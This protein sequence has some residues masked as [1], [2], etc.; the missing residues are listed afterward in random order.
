[1]KG[2][3]LVDFLR[4]EVQ[5][6]PAL[7]NYNH[8]AADIIEEEGIEGDLINEYYT[9]KELSSRNGLGASLSFLLRRN[10]DEEELKRKTGTNSGFKIGKKANNYVK[11]TLPRMI[12]RYLS[13]LLTNSEK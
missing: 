9:N 4:I 8:I 12:E 10:I 11:N 6:A 1:M 2:L 13:E 3:R 5:H 7:V